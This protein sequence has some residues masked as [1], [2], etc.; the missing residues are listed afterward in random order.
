MT[1]GLCTILFGLAV[2]LMAPPPVTAETAT[3]ASTRELAAQRTRPRIII[4]P[5]R[6]GPNAK[7]HCRAQLVQEYR[8]SGTVIV[9]KMRCW[10]Q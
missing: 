4:Q 6:L 10:W 7:R 9:P 1:R 2:L 3:G 5:R 8:V